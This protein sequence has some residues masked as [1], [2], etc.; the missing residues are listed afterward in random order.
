M[1][2]HLLLLSLLLILQFHSHGQEKRI[3]LFLEIDLEDANPF[4]SVK[5]FDSRFDSTIIGYAEKETMFGPA[6]VPVTLK[7]SFPQSLQDAYNKFIRKNKPSNGTELI[8]QV[9]HLNLQE[10]VSAFNG[11]LDMHIEFF[12]RRNESWQ[13][14]STIKENTMLTKSIDIGDALVLEMEK[15]LANGF[16]EAATAYSSGNAIESNFSEESIR[17]RKQY[18]KHLIPFYKTGGQMKDGIYFTASDFLN[19]QPSGSVEQMPAII[20]SNKLQTV[21]GY[22]ENGLLHVVINEQNEIA[23]AYFKN[24]ELFIQGYGIDPMKQMLTGYTI[25]SFQIRKNST[26]QRAFVSNHLISLKKELT[27]SWNEWVFDYYSQMFLLYRKISDEK[28]AG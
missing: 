24:G 12:A 2:Q 26:I 21:W 15:L 11:T 13:L 17:N 6:Y 27:S 8:V 9:L 20:Q 22:V 23:K 4:H 19:H 10:S 18:Y 28:P 16:K 5:V 1:K 7:K 25:G 3:H 14:V